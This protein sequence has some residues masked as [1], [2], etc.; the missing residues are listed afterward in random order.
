MFGEYPNTE[1]NMQKLASGFCY[2]WGPTQPVPQKT[3]QN[4]N[5]LINESLSKAHTGARRQPQEKSNLH[6]NTVTAK[7]NTIKTLEVFKRFEKYLK[8]FSKTIRT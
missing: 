2:H 8:K 7:Y 4:D 6:T 3:L 5:P 1:V